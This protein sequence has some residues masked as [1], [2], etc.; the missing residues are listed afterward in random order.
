MDSWDDHLVCCVRCGDSWVL[1]RDDRSAIVGTLSTTVPAFLLQYVRYLVILPLQAQF[2]HILES[3]LDLGTRL[4]LWNGYYYSVYSSH[5]ANF[6]FCLSLLTHLFIPSFLPTCV[7][8]C[9]WV[10][11]DDRWHPGWS[12]GKETELQT[13]L[14]V[15]RS[16]N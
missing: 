1:Y 11:Y 12:L 5:G 7:C 2:P 16:S 6:R 9:C 10:L 3:H 15:D 8:Y 13:L 14:L 4:H